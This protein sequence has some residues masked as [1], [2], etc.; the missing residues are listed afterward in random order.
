LA[1]SRGTWGWPVKTIVQPGFQFSHPRR[2][3][4]AR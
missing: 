2:G 4:N 3:R 1:L